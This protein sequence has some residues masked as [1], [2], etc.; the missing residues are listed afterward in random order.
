MSRAALREF[1]TVRLV[2][3]AEEIIEE[4]GKRSGPSAKPSG[5]VSSKKSPIG[6]VPCRNCQQPVVLAKTETNDEWIVLEEASGEYELV[7]RKARWVGSEGTYTFHFT[8][9][10]ANADPTEHE[11]AEKSEF[12][13]LTRELGLDIPGY[14][15]REECKPGSLL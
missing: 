8:R 4:L 5:G 12:E 7:D 1:D 2:Q 13:I 11:E 10:P 6:H 9:C 14:E 3:L 15:V